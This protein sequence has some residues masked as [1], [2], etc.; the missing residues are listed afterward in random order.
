MNEPF[1]WHLICGL[2]RARELMGTY[3]KIKRVCFIPTSFCKLLF[4]NIKT[5]IHFP[6]ARTNCISGTRTIQT[7]THINKSFIF[8][9]FNRAYLRNITAKTCIHWIFYY[10]CKRNA[11]TS[12]TMTSSWYVACVIHNLYDKETYILSN[13]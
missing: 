6:T 2:M 12:H 9:M 5:F 8:E 4:N 7:Q 10:S 11:T 13:I 3:R 1:R